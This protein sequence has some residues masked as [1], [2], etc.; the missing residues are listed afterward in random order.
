MIFDK[1]CTLAQRFKTWEKVYAQV[2]FIAIGA[3]GTVGI[4]VLDW[5]WALAYAA[6]YLYG[7]L[8]I[9]MRRLVCPRCPHL[10]EYGD[11]LQAP[12]ALT[13][14]VVG[15]RTTAPLTAFEKFQFYTYFTFVPV[16]PIYWLVAS[17]VLL[18]AFLAAAG[19]WYGAQFFRFCR[20]CRVDQ[21]PA[22]RA[23][24]G[25]R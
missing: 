6:V 14:W 13:R 16:F 4:A 2:S 20:R 17:P 9:V 3:T 23:H 15:E 19:A 8:G 25:L 21:C 22:N 5:R 7:I 18:A 11:C 12:V 1:P 10:H 24:S